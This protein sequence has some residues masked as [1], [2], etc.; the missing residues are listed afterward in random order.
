MSTSHRLS[1]ASA[2]CRLEWRPSRLI[3]AWLFSLVALSP[4][5]LLASGL[6]RWLA[7]PLAVLAMLHALREGHRYRASPHRLLTIRAEG[8]L[9]VDGAMVERWRLH[10]RGPLAFVAWR[11]ADGRRHAL[12]F[13]PDTLG[14]AGRRELRLATPQQASVSTAVGM[15]T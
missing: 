3:T 14:R 12:G 10:W 15:A 5:C 13:W 4:V 7:W 6:P 8:P 9:C 1:S 11:D 2:T